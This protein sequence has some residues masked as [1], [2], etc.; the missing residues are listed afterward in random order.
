MNTPWCL[1]VAVLPAR[2][3]MG[4]L[5]VFAGWMKVHDMGVGEFV[6]KYYTPAI[7]SWLP[8]A[9]AIPYGYFIPWIELIGGAMLVLGL[10]GRLT[11]VVLTLLMVSIVIATGLKPDQSP[12]NTTLI[13]IS[14]TILL[15]ATGPGRLSLDALLF[16]GTRAEP[17]TP[18]TQP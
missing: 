4:L 8:H 13:Y 9:L 5:L 12:F 16:R 3:A 1:S 17:V 7:P 6:E 18:P 15:A 2:L 14:L 10:L 11:A